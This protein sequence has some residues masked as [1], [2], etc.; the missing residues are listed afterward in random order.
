VFMEV[1][2]V[3][4]AMVSKLGIWKRSLLLLLRRLRRKRSNGSLAERLKAA[5]LKTVRALSLSGS[6]PLASAM[7][8]VASP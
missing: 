6:N 7:G 4:V 5:V 3:D 1:L 2:T 8:Y